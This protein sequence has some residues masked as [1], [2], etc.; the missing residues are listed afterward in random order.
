MTELSHLSVMLNEV[1]QYLDPRA[2]EVYVDGTFGG[3]GY[4]RAILEKADCKVIG[5][6]R[7][8]DAVLRAQEFKQKY[9]DRFQMLE[10]CFGDL[11]TLL[12]QAHI[13]KVDGIVLDLGVSSFQIDDPTRGFSFRFNGPLD[14]RMGNSGIS[15]KDLVNSASVEELKFILKTYGDE[16]FAGR[17][18]SEIV[19]RRVATPFETTND[20]AS[21]IRRLVPKSKDGLDPATRSFQAIR[22]VVNNELDEIN[23]VLMAAEKRLAPN[24]RLVVVSF[25]SLEDGLVKHFLKTKSGNIPNVSRFVPVLKQV[26]AESTFKVLTKQAVKPTE[27][28]IKANTRSSSA[29]LRAG[30]RTDAFASELKGD[31]SKC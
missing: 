19:K 30:M 12:D 1:V 18:A 23:K 5:I 20:L 14:M 8:P 22:I 28:E 21:V 7:D 16:R 11:E 17:I 24:G 10:G 29:R 31:L 3:G 2:G 25:H 13:D 4:A 27:A 26:K 9:K 6:D 15:A